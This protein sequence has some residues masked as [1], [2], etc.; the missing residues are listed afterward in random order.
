MSETATDTA[1]LNGLTPPSQDIRFRP[2]RGGELTPEWAAYML[3]LWWT[4][5]DSKLTFSAAIKTTS[6]HFLVGEQP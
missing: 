1:L 3:N 2:G 6:T 4:A 5:R